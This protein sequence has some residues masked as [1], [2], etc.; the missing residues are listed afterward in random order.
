MDYYTTALLSKV[1]RDFSG[2]YKI[3][4]VHYGAFM[5]QSKD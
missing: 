3:E 1:F 5:G 2:T 4:K